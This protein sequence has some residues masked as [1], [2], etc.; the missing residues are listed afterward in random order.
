[1]SSAPHTPRSDSNA[2]QT[3]TRPSPRVTPDAAHQE[4]PSPDDCTRCVQDWPHVQYILTILRAI[5]HYAYHFTRC[6][7]DRDQ[8]FRPTEHGDL[9]TSKKFYHSKLNMSINS[10]IIVTNAEERKIAEISL[11][12]TEPATISL[13]FCRQ[14]MQPETEYAGEDLASV[15]YIHRVK[16]D[17]VNHD[18]MVAR[19]CSAV[20]Y[21]KNFEERVKR[22]SSLEMTAQ[23]LANQGTNND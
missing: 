20:S 19:L 12:T 1:M 7:K 13:Y 17:P 15:E 14:P 9:L 11:R 4:G 8:V 2:R 3:H 10:Q 23:P 16:Y 21:L 18:E 5:G 22:L 6:D